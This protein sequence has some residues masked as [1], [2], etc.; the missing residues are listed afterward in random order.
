[1]VL[2][3][4]LLI[5]LRVQQALADDNNDA[6]RIIHT[7]KVVRKTDEPIWTIL[8]DSL[9]LVHATP[10]ELNNENE[11]EGKIRIELLFGKLKCTRL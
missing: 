5:V 7:P 10:S 3:I 11:N 9:H 4:V 1:M 2:L 8:T 6:P